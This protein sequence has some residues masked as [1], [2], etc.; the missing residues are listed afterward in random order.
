M[1]LNLLPKVIAQTQASGNENPLIEGIQEYSFLADIQ[2]YHL[3]ALFKL[4]N[5]KSNNMKR[6]SKDKLT[7]QIKTVIIENRP[8][9]IGTMSFI[10]QF[11]SSSCSCL[12]S[13][14]LHPENR[15]TILALIKDLYSKD[16][17]TYVL[18]G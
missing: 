7:D 10:L 14:S 2:F 4:F 16:A 13:D 8:N 5:Y 17:D 6:W 18:I 3:N 15:K 9:F 11:V 12:A 1:K